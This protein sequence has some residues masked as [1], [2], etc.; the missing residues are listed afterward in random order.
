MSEKIS[1]EKY[2]FIKTIGEG[3]FGKVKL[4]IH[5]LTEEQVAIKI[6]EKKK[7]KNPKD[8][9]R[10]KKE[11]KYMEMLNHPNIVK[12]YEIIE[13][14]NNYYIVMEYVSGG[15]LFNYIVKNKRLE[16]NEAS[17]FYSQIVHIIQ[18]IHK[19]KICHRD[20]KPENLLLT[21]NKTIKLI[22][23][24]LSNQYHIYLNTPCGSP[25]YASPEVIRGWKYSGLAIDLWASGIILYSMLCGY[26]PF[27]DK[28][29]D[30]LFKK[31]LECK[32]EFPTKKNIIIS[33]S[34][35]D[36][37]K[38]ILKKDPAKRI[39]L[40]EILDHPFLSYGNKKYKERINMEINKQD[41]LIIDY[42]INI[43]KIPN[44]NDEIK[45]DIMKNKHNNNTTIFNLLKKKY[46]EGRLKYNILQREDTDISDRNKIL[47]RFNQNKLNKTIN[48][49][50][51]Y[52]NNENILFQHI[53][54]IN[55]IKKKVNENNNNIIIINNNNNVVNQPNK[56][57]YILNSFLTENKNLNNE[58][59]QKL[60]KIDTSV[61]VEK[62][63]KDNERINVSHSPRIDPYKSNAYKYNSRI[64]EKRIFYK[65]YINTSM[66]QNHQ[67]IN[68]ND[69]PLKNDSFNL[70]LRKP[71]NEKNL[72]L[73]LNYIGF[74]EYKKKVLPASHLKTLTNLQCYTLNNTKDS[75][76]NT[77]ISLKNK[78]LINNSLI[79]NKNEFK[80]KLNS[81]LVKRNTGHLE[82]YRRSP[83]N[84]IYL[85]YS[86]YFN[87]VNDS[88][89]NIVKNENTEKNN[90]TINMTNKSLT[91]EIKTEVAQDN[92]SMRNSINPKVNIN[93]QIL[94]SLN[95]EDES[96]SSDVNKKKLNKISIKKILRIGNDNY[97]KQINPYK[98][99]D[100]RKKIKVNKL[101]TLNNDKQYNNN[102][103]DINANLSERERYP[104]TIY[105]NK[106][107]NNDSN[108]TVN[109]RLKIKGKELTEKRELNNRLAY[110]KKI[111]SQNKSFAKNNKNN[112]NSCTINTSLNMNE[113]C[114]RINDFC[115]RYKLFY[116][117]TNDKY[118][119]I[120]GEVHSFTIEINPSKGG[121]ELKFS[122][123]N[124]DDKRTKEF[125]I[126]LFCQIA[127]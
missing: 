35:K 93:N 31:I 113:I 67:N 60:K 118:K 121:Y 100:D 109:Q 29:N 71:S 56:M 107:I 49:D 108:H 117:Q 28:N 55:I 104:K 75:Q 50:S 33:E 10:I 9:E 13:D 99:R 102:T 86:N 16:E 127:I 62:N 4:A 78:S 89:G 91:S 53:K 112:T 39:S 74:H 65:K 38:K 66:N 82:F 47:K 25:C 11:I 44:N 101:V 123:E 106:T 103:F 59:Y 96:K 115:S 26:L 84:K 83:D 79:Y 111:C 98:Y 15:E 77:R 80:K 119:I 87:N 51:N 2:N 64:K 125:M 17:F 97:Y 68:Q 45:T 5:K 90:D 69:N 14:D 1:L 85:K 30:K 42:M 40:D 105:I 72:N 18:E 46:N 76:Y 61:S 41:K 27:D 7:I 6:L 3:T 12:I 21:Q 116:H 110:S 43:M 37:I 81:S 52:I 92:F 88:L 32:I 70:H 20:L 73:N 126:P 36:L 95:S 24:G 23:F 57:N 22:D 114:K 124:G 63:K 94:R 48:T 120:I 19:H 54:N 122:H 34:G 8:Y 58:R